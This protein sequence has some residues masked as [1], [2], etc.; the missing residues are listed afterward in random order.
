[1]LSLGGGIQSTALALMADAGRFDNCPDVAFFADTR[2]E[3]PRVYE[4][5]EAVRERV[6]FAVE[7]V[8]NGRSLADDVE[9]GVQ[10]QGKRFTPI[11]LF[12]SDGGMSARQCTRQY[13]IEPIQAG[14]RRRLGIEHARGLPAGTVEQWMGIS[15]DEALRASDNR[16]KWITNRFPLLEAG[17]SRRDC[18]AWMAEHHPDI[19]VGKSACTGCPY[20]DKE[21]WRQIALTLPDEFARAVRIDKALRT[22][23]HTE[24]DLK[25]K[26]GN[27]SYLHPARRPL[28]EAVAMAAN[29]DSLFTDIEMVCD[30]GHCFI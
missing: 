18:A 26:P 29:T 23:G 1:M 27:L 5:V 21:A 11:P 9:A 25:T 17:L 13:K 24:M 3:P 22:P 10:A 15:T 12:N 14:I 30:S 28:D 4:T 20:H 6:S 2:W 7:T 8:S 19:P 16:L